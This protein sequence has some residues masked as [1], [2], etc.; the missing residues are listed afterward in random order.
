MVKPIGPVCN[1]NCTYCY[2]LEKNKLYAGTSVNDFHM[3]DEVLESFIRQYIQSQT[4]PVISFVFQGGEPC[5]R[6]IDFFKKVVGLQQKY[7]RGKQIQNSLQTNGTLLT[8][9]FCVFLK[10][11]NFLVGISIDGPEH[12]H[13]IHRVTKANLP[14]HRAV[15]EG[16]R[17][18]K[19]HQVE[20]N[21]LSVVNRETGDH[22]LEV[23]RFLKGIGSRYIQFLPIV[24]RKASAVTSDGLGLV[25]PTFKDE[26]VVTDWSVEPLQYGKFMSRIFDEW[27]RKDVGYYYVQL[28]DATLA[29]WTGNKPGLCVFEETCGNAAVIEHNG[30]VYSCD[31][32]VYPEY[33]LGNIREQGLLDLMTRNTQT[34]FGR[35]KRDNLPGYCLKC[36]FRFACHGGCPKIRILNTPEGDSGLNYL[37]EGYRFFFQHVTHYM[38]YM[39]NEFKNKRAPANVMSAVKKIERKS[40]K[41]LR[42]KR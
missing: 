10:D 13:N 32:F 17:L 42:F 24:E 25:A 6:G 29:N 14:S 30:D 21:T 33:F 8:D 31:H 20:F 23:Y 35:G 15:M 19:K 9:E 18:L 2:Y 36:R 1:L 28:F 16:V 38:D 26:A 41:S 7:A 22:P 39:A 3:S 4:V 5:L 34:Q 12:L 11:H 27:V 40:L 37:C